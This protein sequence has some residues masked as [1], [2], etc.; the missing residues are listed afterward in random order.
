MHLKSLYCSVPLAVLLSVFLV[1]GCSGDSPTT[2]DTSKNIPDGFVAATPGADTLPGHHL[3]GEYKMILKDID[4]ENGNIVDVDVQ[5]VPLRTDQ[6]HADVTNFILNQCPDCVTAVGKSATPDGTGI[7]IEANI[8]LR[9]PTAL[10]GYDVRGIIYPPA[11]GAELRNEWDAQG[12]RWGT[13]D[14]LTKLYNTGMPEQINA[15]MAFNNTQ[16]GRPFSGPNVTHGRTYFIWKSYS[17]KLLA[18]IYKID[19]SFPGNAPEAVD[20]AFYDP[21]DPE[22][23]Y[24]Y[25]NGSSEWVYAQITDWQNDVSVVTLD[26]ANFGVPAPVEMTKVG[27]D[28]VNFTSTWRYHVTQPAGTPAG[29]RTLRVMAY[30]AV[31][32]IRYM[33]DL[34]V[35]VTW[36]DDMPKWSEP[37]KE[38]IY[39]HI[40][41]PGRIWLFFHEAWDVSLPVSYKFWGNNQSSPFDGEPLKVVTSDIYTGYTDFGGSA[42]PPNTE[43]H[44]GLAITDSQNDDP[45]H[46]LYWEEYV[47]TYYDASSKW[48]FAKDQPSGQDGIYGGPCLGD[49][50]GDGIDD[51]VV[52]ARNHMV[53][54]YEGNATS[55]T[56]DTTYWEYDAGGEV[57]VCPA[58][59]DLD[60][61]GRLD[62]IAACDGAARV[63]ALKAQTGLEI[64]SH[65]VE[66][67]ITMHSSPSIAYMNADDTPDVVIGTGTGDLLVLNGIDGSELWSYPVS[68]GIAGTA[69]LADVDDDGV[70]DVC[71]GAYDNKIHMINGATHGK[72][73]DYGAAAQAYNID[74]SPA[75]VDVSGD[76]LPDVI[77]GGMDKA[78]VG[79]GVVY[80]LRG[81]TGGEIWVNQDLWGNCRRTPAPIHIN[82]DEIWDFVVTC[83]TGENKTLYAINGLNGFMIYHTLTPAGNASDVIN[84]SCPIVGDFTG[85]GYMNAMF[86]MCT[87]YGNNPVVDGFVDLYLVNGFDLPG[88]SP[89]GSW[90]GEH[91][92]SMQV[93]NTMDKK[94]LMNSIAAGDVDGDYEWEMV[95][96]NMRGYTYIIDMNA[97]IPEDISMRGWLQFMGNRW[98]NGIP[99]FIPPD[100]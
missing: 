25:P 75:M 50:T 52:G 51:I 2:P 39:A 69:G 23:E 30:D 71:F 77:I 68:S 59:A 20:C 82:D 35:R 53:Y 80:A 94:E 60:H 6:F 48:A 91:L 85:D 63:F 93:S 62:V 11:T 79:K 78:G 98:H 5:L 24:F 41:T 65:Y 31:S 38:G 95:A 76:G 55:P 56:Q 97:P 10:T 40:G 49:V 37:G 32:D 86:G 1:V 88:P 89:L 96:S 92:F 7:V 9:N 46:T 64:W 14:G 87:A 66:E 34:R 99:E 16:T 44:Y 74:C 19:V 36:D 17:Y 21:F 8:F 15:Y 47:A 90:A 84:C 72:M 100:I 22:A 33:R 70:T 13:P 54:V 42:A 4:D 29:L 73:W 27:E 43:R 67:D 12:E 28:P 61:D 18:M 81:D 58:V 26:L 83:Y 45:D 57:Q 3:W